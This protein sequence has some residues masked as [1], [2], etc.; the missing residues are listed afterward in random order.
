M[1]SVGVLHLHDNVAVDKMGSDHI[2]TKRC[3][4]FLIRSYLGVCVG[5]RGGDMKVD[6][7]A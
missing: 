2:R 6:T 5:V 4:L 1:V 7:M 3:V